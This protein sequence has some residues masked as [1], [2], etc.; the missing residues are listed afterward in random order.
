MQPTIAQA[1]HL[2]RCLGYQ[3][4]LE[5]EPLAGRSDRAGL[6]DQLVMSAEERMQSAAALHNA[7]VELRG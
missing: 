4:K 3:L 6:P 2:L 5:L 1:E 7:M